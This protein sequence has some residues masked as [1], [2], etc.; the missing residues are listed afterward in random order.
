MYH[1]AIVSDVKWETAPDWARYHAWDKHGPSW[2]EQR[3]FFSR[4]G[5]AWI[6]TDGDYFR[7]S[8][9]PLAAAIDPRATLTKRP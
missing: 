3:P 5:N 2:F 7:Y 4:T 6:H 8:T 1:T 9:Q